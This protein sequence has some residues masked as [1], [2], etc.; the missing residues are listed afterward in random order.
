MLG[1]GKEALTGAGGSAAVATEFALEGSCG[2][3]RA[4]AGGRGGGAFPGGT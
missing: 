4:E 3:G 1:S 2:T